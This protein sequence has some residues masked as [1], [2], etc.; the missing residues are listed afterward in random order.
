MGFFKRRLRS[1]GML[2]VLLVFLIFALSGCGF[3]DQPPEARISTTPSAPNG[4]VTVQLG[5][6]V[7]F[8]ASNSTPNGGEIAS[9]KWDFKSKLDPGTAT[10]SDKTVNYTYEKAGTYTVKLTV[11]KGSGSSDSEEVSVKVEPG[12]SDPPNAKFT[13]KPDTGAPPLEVD[14]DATESTDPDGSIASYEWDF[15]DGKTAQGKQVTHTFTY[16]FNNKTEKEYSVKLIVTDN[17][18]AKAESEKI[19]TLLQ[20]PPTPGG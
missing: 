13:A 16:D 10:K 11:T 19:I 12:Q 8:D 4:V 15:G 17:D 1:A 3:M 7:S 20:P 9:Y 18:G 6:Q 2:L 5:G 14:F